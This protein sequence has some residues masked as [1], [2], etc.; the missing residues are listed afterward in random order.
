M[1]NNELERTMKIE[2]DI[3][4]VNNQPRES[5]EELTE[6]TVEAPVHAL[7]PIVL[8]DFAEEVEVAS[9]DNVEPVQVL[10]V[11]S[12]GASEESVA[13]NDEYPEEFTNFDDTIVISNDT[14]E[15]NLD[16]PVN[17]ELEEATKTNWFFI[18][19]ILFGIMAGLA[20]ITACFTL[21]F[22]Q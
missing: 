20:I 19:A 1:E 2:N 15:S 13:F 7:E 21:L 11:T 17:S 18:S 3:F 12:D 16:V 5:V 10:E 14:V 4:E 9:E 8:E 6:A 22:N